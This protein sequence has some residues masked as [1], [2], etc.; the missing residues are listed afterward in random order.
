MIFWMPMTNT[1]ILLADITIQLDQ[2]FLLTIFSV[3][4]MH[5]DF[6]AFIVTIL[7]DM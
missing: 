3:T 4:T 6:F 1:M 7:I 5:I 2:F